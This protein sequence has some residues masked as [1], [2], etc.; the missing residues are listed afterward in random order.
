M[1]IRH[2]HRWEQILAR[3]RERDRVGGGRDST[4][5]ASIIDSQSVRA[6]DRGRLR[7]YDSGKKVPGPAAPAGRHA[8]HRT[9]RLRQPGKRQRPLQRS[10]A[11]GPRPRT[12]VAAEARLVDQGYRGQDFIG[13]IGDQFCVNLQVVVRRDGGFHSTWVK[14]GIPQR[15][16]PRFS[17]VPRHWVV[18]RTFAWLGKHRRLA[19]DY[20]T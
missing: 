5:S 12:L 19:K 9:H 4:P 3:L 2:S 11:A 1:N 6:T 7:G 13:W 17:L 8:R 16:L 15:Q 10:R 14:E 18:E 20:E